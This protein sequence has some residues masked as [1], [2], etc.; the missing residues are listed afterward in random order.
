MP[1]YLQSMSAQT[2]GPA[3]SDAPVALAGPAGSQH[4][5]ADDTGHCNPLSALPSLGLPPLSMLF[6]SSQGEGQHHSNSGAQKKAGDRPPADL[7]PRISTAHLM[8]GWKDHK[9]VLRHVALAQSEEYLKLQGVQRRSQQ[10]QKMSRTRFF[11]N[12]FRRKTRSTT[13]LRQQILQRLLK[14]RRLGT[15]LVTGALF[16]GWLG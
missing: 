6:V 16:L 15:L 5:N 10:C 4:L 12:T 2:A 7:S 11:M 8:Q 14:R 3:S 9:Y 1:F 13:T